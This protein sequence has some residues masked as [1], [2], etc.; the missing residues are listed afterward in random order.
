[1]QDAQVHAAAQLPAAPR[2]GWHAPRAATRMA[3]RLR[4]AAGARLKSVT[5]ACRRRCAAGVRA[6]AARG[7]PARAAACLAL[8]AAMAAAQAAGSGPAA[9]FRV[10]VLEFGTLNWELATMQRLGLAEKHGVQFKVAPL[11]SEEALKIALQGRKVDLIVSDWIW[12]AV[13]R[14]RGRDYQFVPHSSV[15]GAIMVD[16]DAGVATVADL[17]GQKIGVAGGALDKS[18]LIARAYAGRKYGLDLAS[19][20]TPQFAGPPMINRLM[21]DRRLSAGINFWHFNARLA[22]QGLEPLIRVKD[23]LGELGL[24]AVP[25]MLGWVFS[26]SWAEANREGLLGF[27]AAAR[28]AKQILASD[29]A[30]WQAIQEWVRPENEAVLA[31]IQ[32]GYPEG[33]IE[34]FGAAEID[35]ARQLFHILAR[36]SDGELTGGAQSFP[37]DTFWSGFSLP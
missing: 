26:Q 7:K 16:P 13:L 4:A 19:A 3:L 23:M 12:V 37:A 5:A 33:V 30:A 22:G 1:M 36:E 6:V 34:R 31:A 9:P 18:W 10:G 27:I 14:A 11:A 24:D 20:T 2:A 29:K 21:L 28:E 32:A 8:A 17:A 35:A 25:P 15:V